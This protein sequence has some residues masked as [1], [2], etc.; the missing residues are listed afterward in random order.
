MAS[1]E[2]LD[3]RSYEREKVPDPF[4]SFSPP[5]VARMTCRPKNEDP[6]PRKGVK[7]RVPGTPAKTVVDRLQRRSDPTI[8][9][10][11]QQRPYHNGGGSIHCGTNALRLI[12]AAD[13]DKWW[14]NL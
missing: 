1:G 12:P 6:N 9:Q 10:K 13:A 2:R 3:R 4:F 14:N 8:R 11:L 7:Y 5:R